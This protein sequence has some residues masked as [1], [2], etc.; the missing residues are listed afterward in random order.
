MKKVLSLLV[1]FV[2]LQ[3]ETWALSGG[4]RYGGDQA[5][6]S[7]T[8][9]GVFT[10]LSGTAKP[11]GSS[12]LVDTVGSNALGLFVIGVPQIDI[13]TGSMAIFF[14]GSFFQGGIVGIADPNKS[15]LSAV[16]QGIHI[17][18][19]STFTD[20]FFGQSSRT[21]DYDSRA[22]GTIKAEIKRGTSSTGVT[23]EGTGTFTVSVIVS[24]LQTF[25]NGTPLDPTD[26]ITAVVQTNV[27]TGTLDFIVDGFKQSDTVVT[28]KNDS[29]AALLNGSGTSVT[30]G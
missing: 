9:A 15:T 4:P 5:A 26:D 13:A 28:P 1:A 7:G 8:Y 29:V 24:A 25:D 2:F 6:V 18:E 23:L 16:A 12:A 10:G 11:L 14:E 21:V 20:I 27:P 30:G 22:D 19:L 3:V 17:T